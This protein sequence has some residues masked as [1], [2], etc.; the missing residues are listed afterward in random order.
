MAQR[1]ETLA[2]KPNDLSLT[3]DRPH[4]VKRENLFPHS[5]L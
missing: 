4:M 3:L 2:A 5:V 1:V